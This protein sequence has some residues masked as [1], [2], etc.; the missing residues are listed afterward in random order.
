[1]KAKLEL[2]ATLDT[3]TR[4]ELADELKAFGRSW[5]EELS[6]G[7]RYRRRA[8]D[9]VVDGSGNLLITADGPAEGMMWSLTRLTFAAGTPGASG[10]NLYANEAS[11]LSMLWRGLVS[12][13][14]PAE[15]GVVL[16][17]GDV[18][19][20]AG[21]GLTATERVVITASV[22]EVPTMLGWSA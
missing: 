13:D 4:A 5:R 16:V 1:M 6:R 3:L 20:I 2:G 19:V 8:W 17:S 7:V 21:T 10:V 9:G 22:K 18:L 12:N 11:A 14:S 15:T